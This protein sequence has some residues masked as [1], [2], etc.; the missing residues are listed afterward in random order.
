MIS[1]VIKTIFCYINTGIFLLL[2]II[3]LIF[4]LE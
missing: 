3:I 4:D 2:I 1:F